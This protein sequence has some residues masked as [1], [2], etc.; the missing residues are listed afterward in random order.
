MATDIRVRSL[1]ITLLLIIMVS[2][3][4]NMFPGTP[5][6]TSLHPVTSTPTEQDLNNLFSVGVK[7]IQVHQYQN[8]INSFRSVLKMSPRMPE[9]YSNIG[10]AHLGL[11]NYSL[12]AE[13]FTTAL[14]LNSLQLNAYWGLAVSLEALCDIPAALGAMR[15]YEHLSTQ[16]DPYLK[17]ARAAIWEW[18]QLKTD[19]SGAQTG[20]NGC[21]N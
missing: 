17:K 8:A 19:S 3:V 13:S 5:V 1:I 20:Q 18:E 12:A 10:F 16:D 2:V 6:H 21:R 14:D 11:N 7:Q 15:T 4:V 9:A